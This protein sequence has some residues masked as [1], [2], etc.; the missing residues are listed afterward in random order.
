MRS[1]YYGDYSY[2]NRVEDQRARRLARTRQVKR[3][4]LFLFIGVIITMA[5]I[6]FFSVK[7][8][9]NTDTSSD[10][11]GTKQY[12]SIMIYCGDTVESIARDNY[13]IMYSSADDM[14]KE[15]RSINH[16]DKED[17]LIPGNYL[18]I[19]Y[20]KMASGY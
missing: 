20:F 14:A 15:I 16:L 13:C 6:S 12:K 10:C 17:R 3:Q 7:A 1:A 4:K 8:F 11:F 9:A 5:F 2:M 19:P 18:V